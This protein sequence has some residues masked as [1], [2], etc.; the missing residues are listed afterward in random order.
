MNEPSNLAVHLVN[1][2]LGEFDDV[3]KVLDLG[4]GG[5]PGISGLP[6][7]L[8]GEATFDGSATGSLV[9]PAFQGH[10][11]ANHFSTVFRAVAAPLSS[12][13]CLATSNRPAAPLS[14]SHWDELDTIAGYSSSLISV[15]HAT[16]TRGKTV[17]HA[18]GQ[19][20]A[21]R[22]SRRRQAF[23]D[24]STINAMAQMQ[25]AS[26][27]DLLALAGQDVPV[28][29]TLNLQAHAGGMLGDLN[30]GA[31][32]TVLGGAIEGQHYH[33]LTAAVS[34]AGQDVN[35]TKLTLLQDG[36]TVEGNGTYNLKTQN[37][38]GQSRWH[39]L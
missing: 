34:L 2:N 12:S 28:T 18:S 36:G 25:N 27:T 10:L 5:K 21:H 19:L 7:H 38:P 8:H 29:G 9:D 13:S 11:T 22:I 16:L 26:L 30:G 17:I 6:V 15:D 23:D 24:Q 4:V 35:L 39:Q 20:Q 31:N 3:L 33:S 37:I 14:T 32:L 1:H